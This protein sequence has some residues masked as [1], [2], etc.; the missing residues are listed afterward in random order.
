MT[1]PLNKQTNVLGEIFGC[2]NLASKYMKQFCSIIDQIIK[3]KLF[4]LIHTRL[5]LIIL[6]QVMRGHLPYIYR[7]LCNR[8]KAF[9]GFLHTEI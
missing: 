5:L 4:I 6:K 2:N 8:R 7:K 3:I 1:T 9:T